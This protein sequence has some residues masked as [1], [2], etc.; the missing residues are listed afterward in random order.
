ME[1][2]IQYKGRTCVVSLEVGAVFVNVEKTKME[3][4][5]EI[6]TLDKKGFLLK[7]V[8]LEKT[9]IQEIEYSKNSLTLKET[10]EYPTM[11]LALALWE[12]TFNK[13]DI[14]RHFGLQMQYEQYKSKTTLRMG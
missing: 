10:K 3:F 6:K 1:I 11:Q 4:Y 14:A 12:G 13:K 9:I 2:K 7:E 5:N 8:D